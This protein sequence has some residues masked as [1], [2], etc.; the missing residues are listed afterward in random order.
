AA[1]LGHTAVHAQNA[2]AESASNDVT[3]TE[4]IVTANRR[5]ESVQKSSLAIDVVGGDQIKSGGVGSPLQLQNLVPGLTMSTS[6]ATVRT[7]LRGVGSLST[8]ANAESAIAYSINGVYIA[9]PNGIGPIFYDLERVE[10]LKGP[11]GTL[12]GRNAT[13]GAIN[14]ISRRPSNEFGGDATL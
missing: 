13:G 5:A 2:S 8:G 9:R 4:V 14:I 11:Q 10:V 6:G 7:Y 1:L 12:Y 3:L